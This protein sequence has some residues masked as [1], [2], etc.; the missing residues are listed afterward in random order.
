MEKQTTKEW[1]MVSD[2][3]AIKEK[4]THQN[5]RDYVELLYNQLDEYLPITEQRNESEIEYLYTLYRKYI[6]F[7]D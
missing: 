7:K 3:N 4:L 1:K 5:Q 6:D 2:L